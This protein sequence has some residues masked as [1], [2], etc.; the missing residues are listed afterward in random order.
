MSQGPV[1]GRAPGT[2]WLPSKGWLDYYHYHHHAVSAVPPTP[3]LLF[4]QGFRLPVVNLG[5]KIL[6]GNFQK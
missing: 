5:P 1:P 4:G 2:E 3:H 6:R